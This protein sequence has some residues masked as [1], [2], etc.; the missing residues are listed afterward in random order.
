M[1]AVHVA[2]DLGRS[3][4]EPP[5]FVPMRRKVQ[6]KKLHISSAFLLFSLLLGLLAACGGETPTATPVPPPPATNTAPAPTNTAPPPSATT[7]PATATPVAMVAPT[8]TQAELPT[9]VPLQ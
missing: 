1:G 5:G 3:A 8:E 6:V 4:G 7:A 9:S 2:I